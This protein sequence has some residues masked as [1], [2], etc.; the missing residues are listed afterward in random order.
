[1]LLE[2]AEWFK[3][4]LEKRHLTRPSGGML[5]SYRA[6]KEEYLSLRTLLARNLGCLLGTPWTFSSAA[7]CAC[8]VLYASEW[9]RREYSGGPWRWTHIL[10]S[11]GQPF[12]LD[13]LERTAAVE[14]GLRAWGHRPGGQ[15]KKYLGAIV[16]HGGL[17]LQL[18]AK[19]D[20]SITRL[21]IRGMR[22]AQLYAWDSTRLESFFEAHD[23]ELVQHLRDDD[24]YCLLASVVSTVLAL[25]HECQ[26]SEEHTSE[27]Q[28]R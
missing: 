7:E 11:I 22:Q 9:W 15:G 2:H 18:V 20:G 28:S 1:M 27:L 26:R 6:S 16:A 17:P 21:L 12:E 3:A 14:R 13:V 19:G 23:L 24:I 8:F 4:F 25:R 10:Q 5:F